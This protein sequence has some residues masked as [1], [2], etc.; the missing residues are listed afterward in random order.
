MSEIP[1]RNLK[2]F[3]LAFSNLE[4][5]SYSDLHSLLIE[6]EKNKSLFDP[7]AAKAT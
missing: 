5:S 3:F 2:T 6:E 7:T 1:I 4:L